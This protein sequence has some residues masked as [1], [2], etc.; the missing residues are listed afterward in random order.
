MIKK[1]PFI[2]LV[3]V[4]LLTGCQAKLTKT[5]S[6]SPKT[7]ATT[8]VPSTSSTTAKTTTPPTQL[9]SIESDSEDIIG[10]VTNN[11]WTAAQSKVNNMKTNF[12]NLKP[13]LVSA[14]VEANTIDKLSSAINGL[15]NAIN[16]KK[17]YDSRVQANQ[18]SKYIPDVYDYY[19]VTIPTDVSRLDYLGREI[20]LNVENSDW[21]S[22]SG[23]Y[24]NASILWDT[25]KVKMNSTTYKKDINSFQSN[26]NA[27][28]AAIDKKDSTETTSQANAF[29]E[30]V[31][32]LE[33]DFTN[34]N[35]T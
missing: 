34:Q 24:K 23:N 15:E 1:I 16:A 19:T 20:I 29:L 21:S 8:N 22:A 28:K 32:T 31:D 10:D 27:L 9:D 13:M 5:A 18:V 26:M 11:D 30:N 12:S 35:K 6:P 4:L 3:I 25:L 17:S 33:A 7:N 14:S 2:I